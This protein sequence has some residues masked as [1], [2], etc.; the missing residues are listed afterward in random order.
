MNRSQ[1]EGAKHRT[2]FAVTPT[3]TIIG[4]N[5]TSRYVF[6]GPQA[7]DGTAVMDPTTY[8]RASHKARHGSR[9]SLQGLI[10]GAGRY[11]RRESPR[12]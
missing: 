1:G 6:S 3:S 12:P 10:R 8:V 11:V 4:R 5:H 7:G 2:F 9:L